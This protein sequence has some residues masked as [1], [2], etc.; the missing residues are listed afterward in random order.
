MNYPT[1]I[2]TD[3][4]ANDN[5]IMES[6]T[7]ILVINSGSSSIKFQLLAMPAEQ[8]LI[9]GQ[10]EQIG[11]ADAILI[12][13]VRDSIPL[14]R[15]LPAP[16][17]ATALSAIFNLLEEQQS[18]SHLSPPDVVS[19]RVVHGGN[20]FAAPV[21]INED[22]IT[23][24]EKVSKL[25]PFHNTA[26]LAGIRIVADLLPDV[27]Q[28]AVFDTTFHHDLPEHARYYGLPLELQHQQH[29][30]R[31]GFHGMSHGY[32][33]ATAA[34]WLGRSPTELKIISLHL[35]NGA[36]ACAIH[37]GNSID[38]SMGFTPL[39]GLVMGSRCGDLDPAL[40]AHIAAALELSSE[41]LEQ[42]LQ[43]Q[44]GLKGLCGDADMRRI[45][46]RMAAGDANARLAFDIFCYRVRKYIGAYY[47]VLNGLDVLV[48]TA[49]IGE[50]SAAVRAAVCTGMD[51]LGIGV[52]SVSNA[53]VSGGIADIGRSDLPVRVLVVPT[54]E[55]LE[56]ARAAQTCLHKGVIVDA[57]SPTRND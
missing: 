32:V 28:V 2:G 54:D 5:S 45:E 22:V 6:L 44:S 25:A 57:S 24:L 1:G 12:Y 16:D 51:A 39:E 38:T 47:A 7:Y 20:E 31:Y 10:M 35:G 40:P 15:S 8:H 29:I 34:Q 55:E 48:F 13:K 17:H 41:Q 33:A 49:G 52:D 4:Q 50:H 46:Q 3:I 18:K 19:H 53:A 26:S 23:R 14:E 21:L 43:Q 30:Q 42:L 9:D 11:S 56:I 27:P 37:G 36:S